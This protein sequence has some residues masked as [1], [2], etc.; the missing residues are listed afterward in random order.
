MDVSLDCSRLA[1]NE[2]ARTPKDYSLAIYE[3]SSSAVNP[4]AERSL[5]L[6]ISRRAHSH[7]PRKPIKRLALHP[8]RLPA[9]DVGV[10][11]L[12][13]D[14]RPK[15]HADEPLGDKGKGG[16]YQRVGGGRRDEGRLLDQAVLGGD[17]GL[18]RARSGV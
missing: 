15:A 12:A 6:H 16:A 11:W 18:L 8:A 2:A 10:L 17:V 7:L 1:R 4:L 14:D 3:P 9:A 13:R 5:D